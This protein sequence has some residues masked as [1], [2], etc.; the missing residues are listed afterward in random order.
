MLQPQGLARL[1]SHP[2][3]SFYS[4]RRLDFLAN[5][6]A[7]MQG[8][9]ALQAAETVE[10]IGKVGAVNDNV[11]PNIVDRMEQVAAGT[12]IARE[13]DRTP[14]M[15]GEAIAAIAILPGAR[16]AAAFRRGPAR[17]PSPS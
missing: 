14:R 15:S 6:L 12:V 7:P 10:A 11:V 17:E 2:L 8:V 16:G 13:G 4:R 1:G 5:P 9:E 3:F